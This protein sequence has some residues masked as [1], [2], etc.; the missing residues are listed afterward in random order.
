MS[1]SGGTSAGTLNVTVAA[2]TGPLASGMKQGEETLKR[3]ASTTVSS[4]QVMARSWEALDKAQKATGLG[5]QKFAASIAKNAAGIALMA[6][7]ANDTASAIQ[8]PLT[9]ALGAFMVGGPIGLGVV[10]LTEGIS[11]FGSQAKKAAEGAAEATRVYTASL[12]KLQQRLASVR[13]ASARRSL[14]ERAKA[15]GVD[16]GF[17]GEKE[18]LER[19]IRQ[20]ETSAE[21]SGFAAMRAGDSAQAK[22]LRELQAADLKNAADARMRLAEIVADHERDEIAK[23]AR[24]ERKEAEDVAKWRDEIGRRYEAIARRGREEAEERQRKAAEGFLKHELDLEAMRAGAAERAFQKEQAAAAARESSA[25]RAAEAA[26]READEA[27][28]A[29]DARKEAALAASRIAFEA[30]SA[31]ESARRE[32][33][34]R[35]RASQLNTYGAGYGPLAQARD[36]KRRDRNIAKNKRTEANLAAEARGSMSI[37]VVGAERFDDNGDP[38]GVADPFASDLGS[39]YSRFQRPEKPVPLYQAPGV[40]EHALPGSDDYWKGYAPRPAGPPV[41][42]DLAPAAAAMQ[43]AGD[44]TADA[45]RATEDAAG[46]AAD[47]AG[48]VADAAGAISGAVAGVGSAVM[49]MAEMLESVK[50][51]LDALKGQLEAQGFF[52]G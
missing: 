11:L 44:A 31:A 6:G 8:G 52:G 46:A 20:S 35:T 30:A 5:A 1:R 39:L 15:S 28:R 14:G 12:E 13:E 50:G 38:I 43:G 23:T 42:P 16:A 51:D 41:M 10:A 19:M 29:A 21:L 25:K 9:R 48:R 4:N 26:K 40:A 45:A 49:S 3:F 36:A 18:S 47:G 24:A 27:R 32:E 33:A 34:A 2:Q 22:R 17:L 37:G 7:A